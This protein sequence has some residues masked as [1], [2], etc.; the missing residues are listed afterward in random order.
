[1]HDVIIIDY[2]PGTQ[3]FDVII[4]DYKPGTQVVP[5]SMWIA[6]QINDRR[7][8]PNAWGRKKWH[9]PQ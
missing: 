5:D 7:L 4:I 1:M 6:W 2:K 3:V 9:A 8:G